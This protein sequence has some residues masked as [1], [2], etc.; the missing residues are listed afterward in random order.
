MTTTRNIL[1]ALKLNHFTTEALH[2]RSEQK[3][4]PAC[5]GR[6]VYGY[7]LPVGKTYP[8][9]QTLK[10]TCPRCLAL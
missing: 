4:T 9:G 8:D 2:D 6:K 7:V 1:K 10:V 5:N 3:F